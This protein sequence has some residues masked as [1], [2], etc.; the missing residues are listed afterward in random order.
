VTRD[1]NLDDHEVR[2]LT[3]ATSTPREELNYR[4]A[5]RNLCKRLRRNRRFCARI[6]ELIE[7]I[8]L[9]DVDAVRA[10]ADR[11]EVNL[12]IKVTGGCVG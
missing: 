1:I 11:I 4:L 6:G 10:E 7:E 5:L 9:Y 2:R 12:R 8:P 3:E